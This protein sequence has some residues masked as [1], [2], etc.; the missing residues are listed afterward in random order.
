MARNEDIQHAVLIV[1]DSPPFDELIKKQLPPG[2]YM[3][4]DFRRSGASARRSILERYYDII[5]IN[6]PLADE[7]GVGLAMDMEEKCNASMLLTVP[8]DSYGDVL[9]RVT[10]AGMLV[11]AKPFPKAMLGYAIRFLM[12]EQKKIRRLEKKIS[13]AQEKA[14]ELR[15]VS[16]AKVMLVEQKHMTENDAHRLIG[17]MAMDQGRSRKRIAQDLIDE[18]TES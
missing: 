6:A 15:L 10:D 11:L 18:L 9:S 12:A 5:I 4:V 13:A 8:S 7:Q 2:K 17:K 14:E 1:S 3:T 16:K